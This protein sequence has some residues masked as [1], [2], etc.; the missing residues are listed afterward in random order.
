RRQ[1]LRAVVAIGVA[2]RRRLLRDPDR[3]ER[4]RERSGIGEHVAGVGKQRQRVGDQAPDELGDHVGRDEDERDREAPP[5][6]RAG[7]GG[8]GVC[9]YGGL[10]RVEISVFVLV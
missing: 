1:N 7:G 4:E 8:V 10:T 2:R 5:V 3:E 9:S 6:R